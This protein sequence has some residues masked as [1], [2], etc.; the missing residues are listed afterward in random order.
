[1]SRPTADPTNGVDPG[2]TV[3]RSNRV[4]CDSAA[5]AALLKEG[6]DLTKTSLHTCLQ[7][8]QD[9]PMRTKTLMLVTMG[10]LALV[11][12]IG[13]SSESTTTVPAQLES[14]ESTA[15]ATFD[16]VL[17]SDLAGARTSADA[18]T[19]AWN[20]YKP[21][22]EADK[23]P[24]DAITAV[25]SAVAALPAALSGTPQT[26]AAARS[27]NA[28]SAPMS[29]LYAVYSPTV[30]VA[31]LDL[32]Y[33]GRELLVDGLALD[34]SSATRHV[35]DINTTWSMLKPKVIAAGGNTE[36]AN[37]DSALAAARSAIAAGN[38]S[39]IQ[40]AATNELE[41]VDAIE[42]VFSTVSDPGD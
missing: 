7:P 29:R 37:F 26:A 15:E 5:N 27:V 22:A 11:G 28:V 3:A 10:A 35:D 13:C 36:A 30:P 40:A 8:S 19:T 9:P 31:V 21:R 2:G 25:D 42:H 4:K 1:M 20:T 14:V 12:N 38:T 32:D 39:D 34:T 41:V 6:N 17:A 18:L 24:A 16:K 33:F 23:A